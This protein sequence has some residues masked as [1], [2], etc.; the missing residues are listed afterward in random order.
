[1]AEQQGTNMKSRRRP[2]SGGI[3]HAVEGVGELRAKHLGPGSF[4][5]SST[6]VGCGIKIEA[7]Q[8]QQQFDQHVVQVQCKHEALG[9]VAVS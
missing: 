1:M 7:R 4:S 5:L 3:L 2:N 9:L 6:A 8:K